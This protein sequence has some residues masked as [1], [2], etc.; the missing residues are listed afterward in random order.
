MSHGSM[1][2]FAP[3]CCKMPGVPA[4]CHAGAMGW[5]LSCRQA[6]VETLDLLYSN[7]FY[8]ESTVF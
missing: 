7:S 5:L 6:Y 8:V 4:I 2:P 1:A 3:I